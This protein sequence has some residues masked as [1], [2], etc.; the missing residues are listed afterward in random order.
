MNASSGNS[1]P[2]IG[3]L[4]GFI[5]LAAMAFSCRAPAGAVMLSPPGL[6]P[7]RDPFMVIPA[8]YRYPNGMIRLPVYRDSS[9]NP[10]P[11]WSEKPVPIRRFASDLSARIFFRDRDLLDSVTVKKAGK[12]GV[13]T[14]WPV[15]T[16]IVIESYRGSGKPGG[17]AGPDDMARPVEIAA[18]FKTDTGNISL[19]GAFYPVDWIYAGFTPDGTPSITPAG[20]RRCHRCH[21]IAFHYTGD[22]VFTR[23]P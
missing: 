16:V 20:V 10:A 23:F 2:L 18:M 15:G 14:F 7:V 11:G 8:G 21:C 17:P 3:I 22:L 19:A 6:R 13:L 12:R 4:V 9:G 1:I 5:C